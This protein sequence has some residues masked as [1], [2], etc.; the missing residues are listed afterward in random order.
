MLT[1]V[2]AAVVKAGLLSSPAVLFYKV[3]EV[4]LQILMENVL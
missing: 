2:L 1:L 4:F 3:K